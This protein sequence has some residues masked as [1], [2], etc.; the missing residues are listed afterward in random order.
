MARDILHAVLMGSESLLVMCQCMSSLLQQ[1]RQLCPWQ[2]ETILHCL[3]DW[4][5]PFPLDH[6]KGSHQSTSLLQRECSKSFPAKL[7][8]LG[9][10]KSSMEKLYLAPILESMVDSACSLPP[11]PTLTLPALSLTMENASIYII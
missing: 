7:T 1:L 4:P 2:H 5:L 10:V 9:I 3:T 6:I 8:G 11:C